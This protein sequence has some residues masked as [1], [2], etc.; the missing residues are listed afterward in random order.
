MA[1]K[2]TKYKLL[3]GKRNYQILGVALVLI[4]IGF[5]LMV[6]GGSDDPDVFNPLIFNFQRIR[7]A[8]T[9][10]LS[11]FVLAIYAIMAK[12]KASQ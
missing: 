10:V 3:F 9:I 1:E 7:L 8:P 2:Q 6:G 11:G 12:P 5:T 4:A